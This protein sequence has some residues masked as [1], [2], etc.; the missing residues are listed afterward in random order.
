LDRHPISHRPAGDVKRPDVLLPQRRFPL[1]RAEAG[2]EP[3][4][5]DPGHC[6][7]VEEAADAAEHL[8]LLDI[9]LAGQGVTDAGGEGF[10]KGHS[11]STNKAVRSPTQAQL[12]AAS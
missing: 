6:V 1:V 2:D 3:V 4:L 7:A 5:P 12:S 8:L 10:V 11:Y 9:L